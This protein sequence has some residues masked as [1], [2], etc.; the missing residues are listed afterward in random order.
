MDDQQFRQLLQHFGL[1]W[2]GYH[3]VRK[4]VK[5]RIRR[6]MHQLGCRNLST[7]LLQLAKNEDA[8]MQ[9]EQIMAVSISRFFRDRKL[10]E[11]LEKEILPELIEKH[12]AKIAVWSVGCACGEEV[13]GR[14][15]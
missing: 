12:R 14:S 1:S 9:C 6:H 7:Y 13:R 11:I 10:W 4:G 3:K 8:K 5:K 2:R 15:L